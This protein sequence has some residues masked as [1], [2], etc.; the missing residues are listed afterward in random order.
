V[1]DVLGNVDE[2]TGSGVDGLGAAGAELD[3]NGAVDDVDGGVVVAVVVP[4]GR[5]PG[6][7]AHQPRPESLDGDGLLARLSRRRVSEATLRRMD[8]TDLVR[9]AIAL[10]LSSRWPFRG[11]PG[12]AERR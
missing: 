8:A 7:S 12:G 1:H 9:V 6:F 11:Y 10:P 2:V 3:A 4:A 5:H